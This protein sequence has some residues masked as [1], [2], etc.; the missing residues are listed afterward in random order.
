MCLHL[1][2]FCWFKHD[3]SSGLLCLHLRIWQGNGKW[4]GK[5]LVINGYVKSFCLPHSSAGM[6][7]VW[8]LSISWVQQRTLKCTRRPVSFVLQQQLGGKQRGRKLYKG[9]KFIKTWL[10][11]HWD[12]SLG[13]LTWTRCLWTGAYWEKGR[14]CL[15]LGKDPSDILSAEGCCCAPDLFVDQALCTWYQRAVV[16]IWALCLNTKGSAFF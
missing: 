14:G 15:L 2:H 6:V 3:I 4:E 13:T 12:P 9:R 7:F 16:Y 10:D 11:S 8:G 5:V 1:L